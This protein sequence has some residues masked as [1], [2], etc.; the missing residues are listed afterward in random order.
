MP[1][2][3]IG[4]TVAA[5]LL[6]GILVY[7]RNRREPLK[8]SGYIE[9]DEIRIGSRVGGRVATVRAI[10]GQAVKAGQPLIE[11]EPFQL[12]EQLTQ[13]QAVLAQAKAELERVNNGFQPEEKAQAKAKVDQLA[14]VVRKLV[15][16]PQEEDIAAAESQVDLAE[17]QFELAK[18]KHQRTETLFA[19]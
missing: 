14:A 15:K 13:A 5:M 11:L 8:V 10:E 2:R 6:I 19:K 12:R 7:S 17:A 16:G 3:A 4:A 1:K 18:L 9:A